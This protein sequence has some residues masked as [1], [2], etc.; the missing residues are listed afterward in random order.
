MTGRRQEG[1]PREWGLWR[2]TRFTWVPSLQCLPFYFPSK[3]STGTKEGALCLKK[4]LVASAKHALSVLPAL[5]SLRP[6]AKSNPAPVFW[7]IFNIPAPNNTS[8]TWSLQSPAGSISAALAPLSCPWLLDMASWKIHPF[9]RLLAQIQGFPSSGRTQLS[10][11]CWEGT[12]WNGLAM[13]RDRSAVKPKFGDKS[14]RALALWAALLC[15]QKATGT[16]VKQSKQMKPELG[17]LNILPSYKANTGWGWVI[18]TKQVS[19]IYRELIP[20]VLLHRTSLF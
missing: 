19:I 14:H 4:A 2:R 15:E 11:A 13:R 3:I 8:I 18:W 6:R 10:C 7:G 5:K 1:L 20:E 12:G 9:L 16:W 17:L